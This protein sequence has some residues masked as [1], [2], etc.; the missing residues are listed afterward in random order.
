MLNV[1]LGDARRILIDASRDLATETVGVHAQRMKRA[2][3]LGEI[4]DALVAQESTQIQE[5]NATW[6]FR[7]RHVREALEVYAGA[8]NGLHIAYRAK[9]AK[10][11]KVRAVVGVLK[12]HR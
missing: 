7:D 12:D 5:V 4:S 10:V 3:G 6:R 8:G 1:A 11:L 9:E 2:C